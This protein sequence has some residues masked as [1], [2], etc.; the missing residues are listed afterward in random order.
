MARRH[1]R[2]RRGRRFGVLYKLLTLVVVCAAAV[3]ALTLFFKVESVEVTGNSRYSAQEIQDACGVSLGDNLYLLSKP[4]MVQKLHQQLPYIDEVRITRRLPNTLCVQVTE[5][6][7]V[8]AVE[9]EGTV[10][11]LTSGGKIV[12]TAA[13]RGDTPLIDGCELLAPSLGGDVSFAL[14]L[15]NRQESLFALLTALESAELTGDVRA[16]HLGDPTVLSMDYTESFTVEMPYGADYPRL[17][18]YLTL[19][20]EELETNLTGVIDLTRDG[21]P[22][23]R[24]N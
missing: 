20:I 1:G 23:F 6:S 12:E 15:Q 3:L 13:E 14:E 16:I 22:H 4:D 11:L 8:Y 24:P 2:G 10:W 21:E 5:F 18:R 17:L 9:Q 7:T 19:V